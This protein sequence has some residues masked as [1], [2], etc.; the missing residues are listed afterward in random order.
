M[1]LAEG[2]DC[3]EDETRDGPASGRS[4]R[5]HEIRKEIVGRSVRSCP[6]P[7]GRGPRPAPD[8]GAARRQA[9][10]RRSGSGGRSSSRVSPRPSFGRGGRT[11][12][13]TWAVRRLAPSAVYLQ[14]SER[15]LACDN[16][17]TSARARAVP[18]RRCRTGLARAGASVWTAGAP[19]IPRGCVLR[20]E[21]KMT[22]PRTTGTERP[23][24]Y[25]HH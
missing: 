23:I 25:A 4:P 9:A 12:P 6:A 18:C 22:V 17:M 5:Y 10:E 11:R 13:T 16:P 1:G 14:A 19:P 7:P 2:S 8:A 24:C 20:G 21:R 15:L 3:L